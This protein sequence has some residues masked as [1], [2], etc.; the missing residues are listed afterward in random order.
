[1]WTSSGRF[2]PGSPHARFAASKGAEARI[3]ELEAKEEQLAADIAEIDRK[4]FLTEQFIRAQVSMLEESI[5]SR[6]ELVKFKLFEELQN[7][8]LNEVCETTCDGV[9]WRKPETMGAHQWR[10]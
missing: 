1:M 3:K 2:R 6:F 10:P 4:L 5:N 9:P 7:G 8:A